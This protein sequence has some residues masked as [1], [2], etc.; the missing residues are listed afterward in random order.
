MN[1]KGWSLVE[2]MIVVSMLGVLVALIGFKIQTLKKEKVEN[3][4]ALKAATSIKTL[5]DC[6]QFWQKSVLCH[7]KAENQ[8]WGTNVNSM[9]YSLLYQNC[10]KRFEKK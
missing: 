9:T 7:E 3:T 8:Y 6:E 10:L 2:T 1:R 5:A 4:D